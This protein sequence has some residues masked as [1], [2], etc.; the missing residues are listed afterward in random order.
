MQTA[1]L[2]DT[3]TSHPVRRRIETKKQWGAFVLG[4]VSFLLLMF[5][6]EA[7][8]LP[9]AFASLAVYFFVSQLLLS[10]GNRDAWRADW[11]IML[12][13]VA[14]PLLSVVIMSLVERPDVVLSQGPGTL[15][16]SCGGTF[17]GAVVASLAAR[18]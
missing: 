4:L 5:V 7:A 2:Q 11:P 10:R 9:A 16:A 18:R 6:G 17:A 12:T 1:R 3:T 13:L 14:V 8:G 15:L